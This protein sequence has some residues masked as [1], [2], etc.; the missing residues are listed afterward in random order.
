[1]SAGLR[2]GEAGTPPEDGREELRGPFLLGLATPL[3]PGGEKGLTWKTV[4]AHHDQSLTCSHAGQI[5]S[6]DHGP[7]G[8][9]VGDPDLLLRRPPLLGLLL[10]LLLLVSP[11]GSVGG[12]ARFGQLVHRGGTEL[13]G[14]EEEVMFFFN[15]KQQQ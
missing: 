3:P 2:G 15:L 6:Q 1:M 7:D 13:D 5:L 4:R 14:A 12:A 8:D 11:P 10:L 9:L